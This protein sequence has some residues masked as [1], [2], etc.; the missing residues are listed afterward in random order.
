MKRL[1][2]ALMLAAV[3][4]AGCNSSTAPGPAPS[5]PPAQQAS[6]PPAPQAT[7][8]QPQAPQ[9]APA[10]SLLP[11]PPV[12][13]ASW[14]AVM[15][16]A[17]Q[18]APGGKAYALWVVIQ[19]DGLVVWREGEQQSVVLSGVAMRQYAWTPDGIVFVQLTGVM[20]GKPQI[21][22]YRWGEAAPK[23]LVDSD[24]LKGY[25][26]ALQWAGAGKLYFADDDGLKTVTDDGKTI[27]PVA[28][29]A[30][31]WIARAGGFAPN[32]P[33]YVGLLDSKLVLATA[34][35]P[36]GAPLMEFSGLGIQRVE[37]T[38]DGTKLALETGGDGKT[39]Q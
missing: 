36:G 31:P 7:A 21:M 17:I 33:R 25:P 15:P 38:P 4:I 29:P 3:L 32:A 30:V 2:A 34:G 1:I 11:V 18:V 20:E 16:A 22:R 6:T 27:A 35:Q 37:W 23:V 9:S 24:R 5:N 28:G 14:P 26:R 8:T 13:R 19:G 10:L 39:G 12:S